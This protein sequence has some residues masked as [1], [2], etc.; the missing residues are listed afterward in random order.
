MMGFYLIGFV[1]AILIAWLMK[2]I[3]KSKERSYFVMEMPTYKTPD[4]R[5]VIYTI[6]EKVKVF[7]IDGKNYHRYICRLWAL[8]SWPSSKFDEIERK[9]QNTENAEVDNC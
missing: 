1:S 2:Y 8:S 4:W 3:I 7:L 5:T 6:I 9:Y